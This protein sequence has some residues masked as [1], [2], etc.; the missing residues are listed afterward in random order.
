MTA[1]PQKDRDDG[2]RFTAGFHQPLDRAREIGLQMLQKGELD[3]DVGRP[4]GDAIAQKFKRLGPARVAPAM[5]EQSKPRALLRCGHR[6]DAS[7][8]SRSRL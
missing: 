7:Q 1:L 6:F 5:G 2:Y 4:R 8:Y 3:G